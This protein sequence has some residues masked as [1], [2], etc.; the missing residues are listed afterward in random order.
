[1][2]KTNVQNE[3]HKGKDI[4]I[5]ESETEQNCLKEQT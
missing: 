2:K 5:D 1:M 3:N 4:N